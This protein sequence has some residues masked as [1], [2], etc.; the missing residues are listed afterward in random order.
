MSDSLTSDQKA[1]LPSGSSC[2]G[3]DLG[4]KVQARYMYGEPGIFEGIV[5]DQRWRT[6]H[7]EKSPIGVPPSRGCFDWYLPAS[8][9]VTLAAAQALRWWFL[10][11]CGANNVGGSLCVETRI[12]IF[13]IKHSYEAIADGVIEET[14]QQ[15]RVRSL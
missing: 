8:G 10:A 3:T 12:V 4:Y 6:L 1:S 14:E 15:I 2:S 5:L 9:C 11:N 13:K 7:F